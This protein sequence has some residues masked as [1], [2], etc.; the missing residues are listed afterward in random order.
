MTTQLTPLMVVNN[1]KNSRG[2]WKFTVDLAT[3][4]MSD[5]FLMKRYLHPK[6]DMFL[7]KRH[8]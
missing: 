2:A 7:Q 1:Q 5:S 8:T 4:L 6:F 3:I